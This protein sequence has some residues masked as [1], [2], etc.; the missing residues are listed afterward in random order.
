MKPSEIVAL[1]GVEA[2]KEALME[3][4]VRWEIDVELPDDHP[5]DFA[6]QLTDACQQAHLIMAE[7][8][9][10]PGFSC[11]VGKRRYLV[12]FFGGDGP[13]DPIVRRVLRTT[14][15]DFSINGGRNAYCCIYDADSGK[16][17]W[18]GGPWPADGSAQQE[19]YNKAKGLEQAYEDKLE[20]D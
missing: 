14:V 11:M 5:S 2:R 17:L 13:D 3:V 4:R 20:E 18:K 19:A 8:E 16:L 12:D 6:G 9:H 10:R 15:R 1:N 7:P